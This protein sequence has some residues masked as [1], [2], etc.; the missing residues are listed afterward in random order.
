[1]KRFEFFRPVTLDNA[2]ALIAPTAQQKAQVEDGPVWLAGGQSLLA[3][4]RLGMASPAALVDLQD[5][6]GLRDIRLD[7]AANGQTALW[8]GAMAT[9]ASVAA[10]E[11]VRGFAPGLAALA[12]HIADAQVRNMGTIGGSLAHN[13]PAACWPAGVLAAGA[14][15]VTSMRDIEADDYFQGLYNTAL[16]VGELIVGVRFLPSTGMQYIKYEQPASRFALTG[17]AVA[18]TGPQGQ[19]V[20]VAVTGLGF[21][22]VRW[23]QA[24]QALAAHFDPAVLE[25]LATASAHDP[26]LQALGDMHASAAYRCHLAH[27]LLRRCVA[28]LS[29]KRLP[30]KAPLMPRVV[31]NSASAPEEGLAP[32]AG[33]AANDSAAPAARDGFGGRQHLAAPPAKVWQAI[34]DPVHL[35][36]SIPGCEAL[37]RRSPEAYEATV[38]VGLGPLSVRFKS[39][40]TLSDLRPPESL[41][42]GFLG[43]AGALGSGQG[44]AQVRLEPA[45]DG[46]TVLHWWVQVQ[47]GGRLAQFGNRLVEASARQLSEEFFKRFSALLASPDG[48]MPPGAST[49]SGAWHA[50]V[51]GLQNLLRRFVAL[52]RK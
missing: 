10:S 47:L 32:S 20:R 31:S 7:S 22:V 13:D 33:M 39:E 25:P 37:V 21:G 5:V 45:I 52:L 36:H 46:G 9:H 2:L 24:E 4:M 51:V 26:G 44:T 49:P 18:R 19:Q 28:Q 29:G 6:P 41:T 8:I 23:H 40:V 35:Q 43:Q 50:F 17:V 27:V 15:V 3:A 11:V 1:M 48:P 34:L 12:G 30:P 42:L 14:T 38:K 16:T